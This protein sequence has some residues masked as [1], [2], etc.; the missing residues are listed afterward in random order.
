MTAVPAGQVSGGSGGAATGSVGEAGALAPARPA[1]PWRTIIPLAAMMAYADGF[2]MVSLRGAVGA[3]ERTQE[4]FLSWL[5]ESTVLLPLFVAAVIAALALALRWFGPVL[6]GRKAFF[7]TAL[8]VAAAGT[9]AGALTLA[10]SE[11][12]D[13]ALQHNLMGALHHANSVQSVEQLD[14]A[15]LGLQ[16]AAFG[17]GAALLLAT[18]LVVTGW[19]VAIQGGRLEVSRRAKASP[20]K[21]AP[22]RARRRPQ[23]A[24]ATGMDLRQRLAAVALFGCAAIHIAVIPDHLNHWVVASAFFLALALA[25]VAGGVLL[26]GRTGQNVLVGVAAASVVPPLLWLWSRTSGLPF[27]PNAGVPEPVGLADLAAGLLELGTLAIAVVLLRARRR[28]TAKPERPATASAHLRALAVAGVI[29]VGSLGVAGAI[30]GWLGDVDTSG[31]TTHT[32][33]H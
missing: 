7:T 20:P 2:W 22:Q 9:V 28:R 12:W 17:Y 30:P 8:L 19:T 33:P 21:K 6:A 27:G 26:L 25:E 5:R 14:Q 16:L 29:A 32:I 31:N 10:A 4:P 15:S 3:I 23:L 13:Y 11:A 18:N 1:V 24:G